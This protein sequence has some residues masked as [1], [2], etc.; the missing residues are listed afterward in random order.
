MRC[1]S[2]TLAGNCILRTVDP[3]GEL[4]PV[5]ALVVILL[6][7][8]S[9][10]METYH[11]QKRADLIPGCGHALEFYG[12]VPKA[13]TS[14]LK[15]RAT[16]ASRY[17]AD[18]NRSFKD[19]ARNYNCVINPTCCYSLQDK[20]LVENEVHIA[21]QRIYYSLYNMNFLNLNELNKEIQKLLTA[22]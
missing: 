14:D 5:E 15:S 17:Q 16:H 7:N 12:G 13:I 2:T 21:Y 4:I 19:F 8:Q 1:I 9:S 10:Y 6:N 22:I 11:S 3:L 20:S 18:I